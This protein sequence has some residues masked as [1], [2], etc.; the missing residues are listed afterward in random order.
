MAVLI[1][2]KL[3]TQSEKRKDKMEIFKT[4]MTSRI[5]GWTPASVDALNVID[6]VFSDDEG[7][8]EAWKDLNEKYHVIT[9]D[10]THMKKIEQAQYK[11]LEEIAISLGYRE[12][13]S[14]ETIQKPY[15]PDGMLYQIEKQKKQQE[16]YY[17]T[18]DAIQKMMP[19][20]GAE[21][22]LHNK[23]NTGN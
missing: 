1:A 3:Q 20:T 9:P 13:I 8:R 19:Q 21:S 5:Y 4:L 14:W 11:L 17:S 2:H 12:M 16:K 18:L 15:M 22:S 7:V 10:D 6:I 23:T